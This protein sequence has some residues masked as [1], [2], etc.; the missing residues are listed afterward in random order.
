[1]RK[2]YLNL[3]PLAGGTLSLNRL[4]TQHVGPSSIV[5]LYVVETEKKDDPHSFRRFFKI[6]KRDYKLRHVCLFDRTVQLRFHWTDFHEILYW[7]F[8]SKICR[9]NW[10]FTKI[11]Q[12]QRALY[13]KTN[14][15]LLSYLNQFFLEWEIFQKLCRER[16]IHFTFSNLFFRKLCRL[17]DNVENF[18]RAE[19][20]TDDNMTHAHFMLDT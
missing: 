10:S 17:W 2:Y 6:R 12:E 8:F 19:Q 9:E 11:L 15:H 18:C 4:L 7:R 20:A 13:M 16:N 1:M 14:K 5:L 3:R